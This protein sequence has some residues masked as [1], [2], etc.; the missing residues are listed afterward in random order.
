[1]ASPRSRTAAGAPDGPRLDRRVGGDR[2]RRPAPLPRGDPG[3][4][5][6]LVGAARGAGLL[7]RRLRAER[8]SGPLVVLDVR[9]AAD[10]EHVD[11]AVRAAT[12]L[13]LELARRTGCE[14]LLPGD[15]RPLLIEPDLG[16]WPGAHARLALVEGGP[17]APPPSMSVRPRPGTIF[18]VS[19]ESGRLPARLLR[20]AQRAGV[21]VLPE[22]LSPAVRGTPSF[23]VSGCLGYLITASARATTPRERAA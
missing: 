22:D 13:T 7:E 14:L 18:Y 8:D 10:G 16:A 23:A 17:E 2:G 21:L 19:A 15:R 5:D 12:S 6:Q 9:A 3:L 4:A 1:M 20:G 11:A